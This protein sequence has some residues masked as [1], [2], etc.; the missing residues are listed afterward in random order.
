MP[1][2]SGRVLCLVASSCKEQPAMMVNNEYK[3][4]KVSTTDKTLSSLY[5]ATIR[6]V[7][8]ST[9]IRRFQVLSLNYVWKK[10]RLYA[11]DNYC[12]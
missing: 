6:D 1:A 9:S 8:T 3:V 10:G 2:A 4:L 7:R 12:L 5:S 11:K